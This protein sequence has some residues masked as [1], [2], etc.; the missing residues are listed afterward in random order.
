VSAPHV[1][2]RKPPSIGCCPLRSDRVISVG[3]DWPLPAG[4]RLGPIFPRQKNP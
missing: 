1:S 3:S 2:G 4:T